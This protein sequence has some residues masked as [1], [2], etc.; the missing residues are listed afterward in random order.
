MCKLDLN[1][2]K[3]FEEFSQEYDNWY[4][5]NIHIY[6][7]ELA[8]IRQLIP[9]TGTGLEIGIGTGRFAIPLG[10]KLGI[11]PSINM[12]KKIKNNNLSLICSI[13]ENL[14][15]K[16]NIL[17]FVFMSTTLCFLTSVEKTFEQIHMVLRPNG[18]FILGFID[19]ET[20]L[21]ETYL[22]KKQGNKFYKNAIFY[23]TDEVISYL[24]KYCFEIVTIKQGLIPGKSTDFVLNGY[25]EGGF[26]VIKSKKHRRSLTWS[27]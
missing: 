26:V 3:P 25:G 7:G 13:G 14:P 6:K 4:E 20:V 18:Y 8:L 27:D 10:I 21:G 19:R 9:K 15:I 22:R 12:M 5:E 1:K 2:I 23:S 17:D 16:P 11:D 24:N